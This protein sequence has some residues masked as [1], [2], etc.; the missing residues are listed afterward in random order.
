MDYKL[1]KSERIKPYV[2]KEFILYLLLLILLEMRIGFDAKRAFY[3][4]TGLG[5]YSRDSIRILSLLYPE[6]DYF[7]Y[8]PKEKENKQ[9]SFLKNKKNILVRTPSSFVGNLF[10][11][12]WRNKNIIKDLVQDEIDIYHGLSHEIPLG[13]EKTNIKSVVTIHDLIFIRYPH[14]F[15]SIDRKIYHKKFQSACKRANKIIAIS[16]QTKNDIIEFFGTNKNKI[17]VVYQGCNNVFQSKISKKRIE[18]ICKKYNLPEKFILNVGTIEERKNLLTILKSIKELPKQHLVVIGNGKEYKNKCLQYIREHNLQ[19]RVSFL[20][21]IESEEM[22]AIYQKSEIMIYPSVFEGFG[23]PILEALFSKTPVI[24]SQGGCFSETGG[25]HSIY[26][27][28]LSV[29]EMTSAIT[30][31]TTDTNVRNTMIEKGYNYAQNFT[32]KKVAQNLIDIYK[33]L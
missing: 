28:P 10:K 31:I 32:D 4:S 15:S 21:G 29:S 8:T 16:H 25:E 14:L 5:N 24:T 23:I 20:S 2:K 7:L 33:N 3:N 27:D 9:I 11:K 17:E 12:Y 18:E 22:A 1:N 26:I 6:N 13:I 19:D 30:K